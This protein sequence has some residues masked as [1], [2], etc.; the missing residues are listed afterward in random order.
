MAFTP[1]FGSDVTSHVRNIKP[2]HLPFVLEWARSFLHG[3]L[4]TQ[5]KRHNNS[6][7]IHAII[8]FTYMYIMLNRKSNQISR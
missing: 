8:I 4:N 6:K 2:M 5:Q 7:G 1:T 3:L